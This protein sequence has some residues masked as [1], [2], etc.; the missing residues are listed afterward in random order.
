VQAITSSEYVDVL[1][2]CVNLLTYLLYDASTHGVW[3]A[4]WYHHCTCIWFTRSL[5]S[6]NIYESGRFYKDTTQEKKRL[7]TAFKNQRKDS[8]TWAPHL[9]HRKLQLHILTRSTPTISN[10]SFEQLKTLSICWKLNSE[11]RRAR[12]LDCMTK[13]LM[14]KKIPTCLKELSDKCA[15]WSQVCVHRQ[16][17][18]LIFWIL[19]DCLQPQWGIKWFTMY[20]LIDCPT[21]W[22]LPSHMS[23]SSENLEI[24]ISRCIQNREVPL[25]KTRMAAV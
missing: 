20:H 14:W 11:L 10:S 3:N 12:M 4:K 23:R 22:T 18:A 9:H 25:N 5:P 16:I 19:I 1:S 6:F 7:A 8:K 2:T 17:R 21:I 24:C 13:L 15:D